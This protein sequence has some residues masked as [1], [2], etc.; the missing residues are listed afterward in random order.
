M[1]DDCVDNLA[2]PVVGLV[3]LVIIINNNNVLCKYQSTLLAEVQ[4]S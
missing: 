1:F 3:G 4:Q 2:D